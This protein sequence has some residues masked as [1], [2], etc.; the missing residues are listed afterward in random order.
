MEVYK[1]IVVPYDGSTHSQLALEH[2]A[3]LAK[4]SGGTISVL[5]VAS[6]TSAATRI[7]GFFGNYD[8]GAVADRVREKGE[9]I[10][11]KAKATIC[12]L[13]TSPIP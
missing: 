8:A 6:L 1:K 5:Y 3:F 10:L 12:L 4:L 7:S 13:Y 11:H 9:E 2:A